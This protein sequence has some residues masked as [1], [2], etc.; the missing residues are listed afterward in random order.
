VVHPVAGEGEFSLLQSI[1]TTCEAIPASGSFG[2]S[3]KVAGP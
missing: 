3:G 2:A 1:Q